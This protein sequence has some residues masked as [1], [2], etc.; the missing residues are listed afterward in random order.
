MTQLPFHKYQATGN[1]F[2]LIDNRSMMVDHSVELAQRLCDRKFGIGSDGLIIIQNHPKFDFEM[3]FY[4]PDGSM[5]LCGN[6]SR[7]AVNFTHKLGLIEDDCN[8]LAYDGAHEASILEGGIV[9]L[10]MADVHSVRSMADGTFVDTGSPHLMVYLE[11]VLEKD[12]VTMGQTIRYNDQF[13]AEGVNVNFVEVGNDNSILVRTYERGVENE[14]LSC[15][16]GVTAAA[17]ASS[18]KGLTSPIAIKTKGGNLKVEFNQVGDDFTNV[19]LIGPAK[20]VYQGTI[21]LN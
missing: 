8:F 15:G 10:R 19:Y 11:N 4:N 17:I 12:V 9:R 13:K 20:E 1:D 5:S 2:I 7:C 6:G 16:T 18:Q 21:D 14:T 3:I